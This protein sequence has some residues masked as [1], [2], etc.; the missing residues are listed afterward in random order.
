MT[1]RRY[2]VLVY[3]AGA[4]VHTDRKYPA[5]LDLDTSAGLRE[6]EAKL[7]ELVH[8]LARADGARGDRIARYY[9]AIHDWDS[10][11]FQFHWPARSADY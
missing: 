3:D 4:E 5:V 9:L 6:A 8:T 10:N 2:R 7:D 1:A 11:E